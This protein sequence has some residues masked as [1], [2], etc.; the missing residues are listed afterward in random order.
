MTPLI[1]SLTK[2]ADYVRGDYHAYRTPPT[3]P[4]DS[5]LEKSTDE[6]PVRATKKKIHSHSLFRSTDESSDSSQVTQISADELGITHLLHGMALSRISQ[7]ESTK[8]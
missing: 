4:I 3:D 6:T 8:I 1:R 5:S 7:N 2:R